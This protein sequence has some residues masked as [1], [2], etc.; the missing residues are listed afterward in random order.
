MRAR[1]F[2]VRL[3]VKDEYRPLRAA[4][5]GLWA[6]AVLALA[7]QLLF[8]HYLWGE[9]RPSA[10]DLELRRPPSDAFFRLAALGDRPAL[11][12]VLMLNLQAFDNQQGES[13]SFSDLDYKTLGEWLD[14]IT[15][16]DQ[17]SEYP[18]FS[19]AKIYTSPPDEER[20]RMMLAW[21]RRHFAAKNAECGEDGRCANLRWEW[22]A[23]A[24]NF[25]K[26]RL[27]DDALALEMAREMRA[28]TVPGK[29]PGWTRQMEVFFRES[30]D[31]FEGAANLLA[32]LLEAGEVSDPVEFKFLLE[33][34]DGIIC[35]IV[36]DEKTVRSFGKF[37][38][39]KERRFALLK[40]YLERQG[41][42]EISAE[43]KEIICPDEK[44]S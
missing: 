17:K 2:R 33:R 36:R 37:N 16:L 7:A 21:V 15:A 10:R 8:H 35:K 29:V 6:A 22:M 4:P 32:H 41:V 31:E 40:N 12:R 23:H 9:P 19:A 24:A 27:E 14:R 18:H 1:R 3:F 34:L 39:I 25:A 20:Q 13:I 11:A 42:Y 26:H 44:Q 5:R 43:Q 30:A 38:E 28:L